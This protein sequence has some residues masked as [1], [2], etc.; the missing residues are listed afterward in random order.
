MLPHIK[1][2]ESAHAVHFCHLTELLDDW[3]KMNNDGDDYWLVVE[4]ILLRLLHLD[5]NSH[6]AP[7]HSAEA[8]PQQVGRKPNKAPL[9]W[10]QQ[11]RVL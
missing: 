10:N 9:R 6:L 2:R 11:R 1:K 8:E 3:Y 4:V 7:E 5:F